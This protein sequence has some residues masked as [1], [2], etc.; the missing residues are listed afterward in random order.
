MLGNGVFNADGEMWKFHRAMT[1]PFF[2]RDRI[3]DFDIFARHADNLLARMLERSRE[4]HALDVQDAFGRFTLDSATEFLFGHCVHALYAGLPYAYNVQR[5]QADRADGGKG[6]NDAE[7]FVK[8]FAEAQ[9]AISDRQIYGE[10]WPLSETMKDRT[11]E[12][13]KVVHG[14]IEPIL[15][16]A[17][18]KRPNSA[19]KTP[20]PTMEKEVIAEEVTF[21]DHLVEHTDGQLYSISPTNFISH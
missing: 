12:P 10:L 19:K 14:F 6:D 20:R 11:E 9:E 8:A 3:S 17:L 7:R 2:S 5:M 15:K 16:D 18:D 13:M 21:L 1:R 4:G